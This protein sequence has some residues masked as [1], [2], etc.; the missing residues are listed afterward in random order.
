MRNPDATVRGGGGGVETHAKARGGGQ[1]ATAQ[2]PL[3][4]RTFLTTSRSLGYHSTSIAREGGA[5]AKERGREGGGKVRAKV[6]RQELDKGG[7]EKNRGQ[8]SQVQK[9]YEMEAKDDI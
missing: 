2:A 9:G 4:N 6:S 5:E 3:T 8:T 1:P 7:R